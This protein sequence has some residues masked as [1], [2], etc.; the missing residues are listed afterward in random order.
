MRYFSDENYFMRPVGEDDLPLLA[1]HRNSQLTWN[2]LTD[3]FPKWSHDQVKWLRLMSPT[4]MYFIVE[5]IRKPD[6]PEGYTLLSN[7]G[8][9]VGLIRITDIDFVNSNSCVG[10]DVFEDFRGQGNAVKIMRMIQS[11]SF[12]YLNMHRLWLLV[13]E[14]N[15]PAIKTYRRTG[16]RHEGIMRDHIY[17]DGKYY[18][19][20]L[21]GI[22]K[23]EWDYDT[24]I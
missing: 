3:I 4:N 10:L 8:Q 14:D 16:F 22:S 18:N 2:G 21:M 13:K 23:E 1:K 5:D 17:R 6:L 24:S 15:I 12:N 9:P 7:F 19:Y 11:Y 20:L